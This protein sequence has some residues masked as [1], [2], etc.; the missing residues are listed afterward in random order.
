[1]KYISSL[2]LALSLFFSIRV[3]AQEQDSLIAIPNPSFEEWSTGSG[4]SVTVIFFPLS[5]YSSYPYPT[6]WDYPTYPVNE[7]LS[8]SGMNVNVN[9][10]LPLLKV[11]NQTDDTVDGSHALRMQSFMLSDIISSTVYGL[12]SSSLDPELTSTVFPNGYFAPDTPPV[13]TRS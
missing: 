2:L 5:V 4:Y 6:G 3:T 8:Y 1:M 11:S 13:S 10:N 12:A 9:T 7:T